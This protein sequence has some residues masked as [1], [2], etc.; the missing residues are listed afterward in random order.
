GRAAVASLGAILAT[1]LGAF[2][3]DSVAPVLRTVPDL[4]ERIAAS[5]PL[6]PL[7]ATAILALLATVVAIWSGSDLLRGAMRDLARRAATARLGAALAVGGLL[8]ASLA[9]AV[10][11]ALGRPQ[12]LLF[13]VALWTLAV[14]LVGQWLAQRLP[15]ARRRRSRSTTPAAAAPI[16]DRL[17]WH[18]SQDETA[19]ARR[20]RLWGVTTLG[21]AIICPAL[22]LAFDA[23]WPVAVLAFA[24]VLVAA[25]PAA[26][27]LGIVV[28]FRTTI[29]EL[30]LAGIVVSGGATLERITRVRLAAMNAR[31]GVCNPA[32]EI[33]E[34][35]LLDGIPAPE[36]LAHAAVARTKHE[37][38]R[39]L[40]RP[41]LAAASPQVPGEAVLATSAELSREGV[42]TDPLRDEIDVLERQG[43]S[44]L[45]V[46]DRSRLLG[47]IALVL[48]P[49]PGAAAAITRLGDGGTPSL[50]VTG[51]PDGTAATIAASLGIDRYAGD[52]RDEDKRRL[53][54]ESATSTG[55]P[56]AWISDGTDEETAAAADLAI[57]FADDATA[58]SGADDV[59]VTAGGFE[60]IGA[61]FA[62]ARAVRERARKQTRLLTAYHAVAL[63]LAGGAL[64]PWT[65]LLPS[66]FLSAVVAAAVVLV[67]A[68]SRSWREQ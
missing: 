27:L 44:V 11:T 20:A 49:R 5:V 15:V 52:A 38:A 37:Y 4:R 54:V 61:L 30:S 39:A 64:Y 51:H 22:L 68:R 24:S 31:G 18:R 17:A 1:W 40:I 50:L 25:A 26:F 16:L 66:P 8:A 7:A 42:S 55:A 56:V 59:R 53:I 21:I 14:V 2:T 62:T 28:P 34:L 32:A 41:R 67:A 57:T 10:A 12:P 23:R 13:G 33:S 29:E 43:K 65:G 63:P 46:A 60:G 19:A 3:H 48:H 6:H 47:G 36:L 58:G 9:A 45:L 35:L